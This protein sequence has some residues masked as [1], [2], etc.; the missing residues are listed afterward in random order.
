[1]KMTEKAKNIKLISL[2]YYLKKLRS[3]CFLAF[4]NFVKKLNVSLDNPHSSD[5]LKSK[6]VLGEF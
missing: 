5:E 6:M 2:K 1:M 4:V 3:C